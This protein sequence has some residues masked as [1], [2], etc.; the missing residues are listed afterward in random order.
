MTYMEPKPLHQGYIPYIDTAVDDYGTQMDVG[1]L[2]LEAG[3]SFTISE[4]EKEVAVTGFQ[5]QQTHVHLGAVVIH[6]SVDVGD[7]ALM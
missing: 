4:P 1:L 3:D 7:I 2:I 6:G 5:N